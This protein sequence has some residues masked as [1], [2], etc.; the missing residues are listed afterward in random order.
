[1]LSVASGGAALKS[2]FTSGAVDAYALPPLFDTCAA[3]PTLALTV[4]AVSC[5]RADDS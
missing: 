1:M 5:W 3:G 2:G 4:S